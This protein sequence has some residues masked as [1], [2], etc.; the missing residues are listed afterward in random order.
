M[1]KDQMMAEDAVQDIFMKVLLNL[2]KFKAD[3]KFS[4][5]LYSITYN[6]CIDKIRRRKKERSM[7]T[8]VEDMGN[9]NVPEEED[10]RD[11]IETNVKQMKHILDTMKVKDKAILLMKYQDEMS[12]RDM[13]LVLE[14]SESA[15][16][17]SIKRAKEKFR[18]QY[19]LLYAS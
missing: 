12:I 14:K 19:K 6:F 15:I 16:K 17:M 1:L 9:L 3:S 18:E 13:T 7:V 5:W 8:D 10:D 2:S 11:I 4:T